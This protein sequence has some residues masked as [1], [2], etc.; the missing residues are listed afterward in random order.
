MRFVC[1]CFTLSRF[2]V[3]YPNLNI[4]QPNA[5]PKRDIGKT[6]KIGSLA[7]E[8]LAKAKSIE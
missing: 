8:N 7:Q 1:L 3:T 6:E 5:K 4:N 2:S